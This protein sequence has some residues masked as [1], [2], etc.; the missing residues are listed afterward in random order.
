MQTQGPDPFPIGAHLT[1]PRRGYV[2]HG[3]YA[4]GGRV[5]HYGGFAA[6][7]R[8]APVQEVSLDQF[9]QGRPVSAHPVAAPRFDPDTV[10][11]RARSRL[12]ENAYDV[13]RNNCEHFVHWCLRGRPYSA[14]VARWLRPWRRVAAAL[15]LRVREAGCGCDGDGSAWRPLPPCSEAPT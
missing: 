9:A 2:H 14:Q 5:I 4:G 11:R 3:L 15:G 8:A 6:G 1:T 12:G 7:W 13:L 10:L